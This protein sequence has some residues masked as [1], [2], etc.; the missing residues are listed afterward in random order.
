MRGNLS[1]IIVLLICISD[2][3]RFPLVNLI[4]KYI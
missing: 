3:H 1:M 2:A 4:I